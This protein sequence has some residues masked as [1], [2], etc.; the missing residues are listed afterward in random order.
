M[1]PSCPVVREIFIKKLSLPHSLSIS[2]FFRLSLSLCHALFR[3]YSAA[4]ESF[5]G[6]DHEAPVITSYGEF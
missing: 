6:A 3:E 5:P 4:M 1:L 2:L